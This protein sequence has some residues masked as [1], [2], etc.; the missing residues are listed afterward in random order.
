MS[1]LSVLQIDFRYI[2]ILSSSGAEEAHSPTGT[3]NYLYFSCVSCWDVYER[4]F[5]AITPT[6][7]RKAGIFISREVAEII[8]ISKT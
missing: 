2:T 5:C 7:M 8:K 4:T 1:E 6:I 3:E